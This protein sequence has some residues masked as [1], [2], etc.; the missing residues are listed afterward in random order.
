[1]AVENLDFCH[2]TQHLSKAAEVVFGKGSD[3]A[4]AW[5]DRYRTLRSVRCAT[6]E[7]GFAPERKPTRS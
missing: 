1:V 7:S 5:F 2:A 4:K 6:I 3:E